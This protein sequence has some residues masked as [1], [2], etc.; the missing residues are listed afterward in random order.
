[1]SQLEKKLRYISLNSAETFE[2]NNNFTC[3]FRTHLVASATANTISVEIRCSW[4]IPT[5]NRS[6]KGTEPTSASCSSI[7]R[8]NKNIYIA[9]FVSNNKIYQN[10]FIFLKIFS[11]NLFLFRQN[12]D[13]MQPENEW[14]SCYLFEPVP[15]FAWEAKWQEG[16]KETIERKPLMRDKKR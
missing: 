10:I 6:S 15:E 11:Y 1:M 3:F 2:V 7:K 16:T 13:N 8:M 9:C 4:Y 12:L 14:K 5:I